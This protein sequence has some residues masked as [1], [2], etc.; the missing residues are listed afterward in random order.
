MA[1]SLTKNYWNRTTIVEI[2]DGGWMVCFFET[3]YIDS[4]QILHSDKDHQMPFL[5]GL[6]VRIT[7]PRWRKSATLEKSKIRHISS[8]V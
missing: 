5:G 8:M 2:I 6:N 1:Y 3:V 7:N 4:N